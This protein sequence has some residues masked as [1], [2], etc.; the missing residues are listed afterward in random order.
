[1]ISV[2]FKY[3]NVCRQGRY[4]TETEGYPLD[5]LCLLLDHRYANSLK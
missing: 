2:G 1:M 5:L 4:G 3:H